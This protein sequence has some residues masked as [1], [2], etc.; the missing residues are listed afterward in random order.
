MKKTALV[1]RFWELIS[2]KRCTKTLHRKR[3]SICTCAP[4]T[5]FTVSGYFS[6]SQMVHNSWQ[7]QLAPRDCICVTASCSLLAPHWE[8]YHLT[9]MIGNDQSACPIA[10]NAS[11]QTSDTVYIFLYFYIMERK[12]LYNIVKILPKNILV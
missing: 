7:K 6:T 2:T 11:T 8:I 3:H 10:I 1:P 9:T 5:T 12:M 4:F